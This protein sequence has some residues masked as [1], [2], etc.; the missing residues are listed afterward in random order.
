[1]CSAQIV[2]EVDAATY[3][4]GSKGENRWMATD[5]REQDQEEAEGREGKGWQRMRELTSSVNT[6]VI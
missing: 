3:G 2:K 1:M 4:V 5:V 6:A